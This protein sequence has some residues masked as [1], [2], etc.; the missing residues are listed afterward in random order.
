MSKTETEGIVATDAATDAPKKLS[1]AGDF[2]PATEEQWE[3]EVQKVLNRGR[4]PEK[5]LT[6]EQCLKRLTKT[7]VD[8]IAIRPM[9]RPQD[10]PDKLGYPGV[11]PFTRGTTV[12]NGDMDAWDV[13]ALHEDPDAEFTRQAILTDLERGV[14]SIWL[15]VGADA[16][17]PADVAGALSGVLL[18]MTKVEVSSRDDQEAAAEALLSVYEHSGKPASELQL[19][20]GIDPT[21]L[22]ALQ[23]TTP[24]LS[25]LSTWVKRL[26]GYSTSRAIT[27]DGT[28]YHNAGAGDVAELAW[29]LATAVE[30]VRALLDQGVSAD[31]AFDSINFRVTATH[32]QFLTIARLRALRT[33]WTRIGE[34]FGVSPEKRGARQVAVTSWRELTRQDPYV[35]IL[36]G[37]IATFSASVG[38]AEAITTLPFCSALGLP[39]D[40]FARRIARN[41]GIVLSEE[42]NIGRVNDPAGGSF[43]V[44]SLT[45]SLAKAAWEELQKVEALGGMS[46]ALAGDHVTATLKADNDERAKRLATRKQP[47]TAV[48]EFPLLGAR[49]VE[50][51]PFPAAP[52]RG[53]LEWHRDSEVFEALI[54]RSKSLDDPKVFLAC[55]GTRRD[56]G[57]REGFSAPVWHV[58]GL[59]TTE[60]EGGTTEEIVAAFKKSGAVVADLCSS[61]KVYASQGLEVAKALKE[62]GAKAVYLSG[63]YKELGEGADEAEQVFAGR[64][65]LGMDVVD[66]LS[67]VLDLMGAAK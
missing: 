42:V 30:Y 44:E 59:D 14:T 8:G 5:Q 60:T 6:F 48:S 47:I 45:S 66:V 35:N 27:V 63:A 7:T 38:G 3:I 4:P 2:P 10:A 24:D 39:T 31:E 15:R 56:F 32:D 65:F 37:S 1:L 64:L 20:L 28:I 34:V 16:V 23:G 26:E 21:G 52:A 51:K 43:Y 33:A 50:V 40:D 29:L 46:A 41:T 11:A 25:K 18:D 19:N 54:D 12:R 55:L 62:A 61:A 67:T 53:G 49:T 22:A 17:K 58:G 36:R 57:G 9:Y 13:R